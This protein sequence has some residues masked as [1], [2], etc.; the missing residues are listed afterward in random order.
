MVPLLQTNPFP[1]MHIGRYQETSVDLLERDELYIKFANG[2]V[3]DE[4][5]VKTTVK[6]N[7]HVSQE[8]VEQGVL[9]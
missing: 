6:L 4:P 9:D 7:R 3:L 2:R 1:K 5:L 8:E